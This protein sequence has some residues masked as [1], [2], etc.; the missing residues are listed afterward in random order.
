MIVYFLTFIIADDKYCLYPQCTNVRN[1]G[2]NTNSKRNVPVHM[3]YEFTLFYLMSMFR[4]LGTNRLVSLALIILVFSLVIILE[5]PSFLKVILGIFKVCFILG[6]VML[7][8]ISCRLVK[9]VDLLVQREVICGTHRKCHFCFEHKDTF[10]CKCTQNLY[11]QRIRGHG[12][13]VL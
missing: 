3:L 1:F 13:S 6:L 4:A 11:M 12:D 2:N 9:D 7:L 8:L 10:S 5:T